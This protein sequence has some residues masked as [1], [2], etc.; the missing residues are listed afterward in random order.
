MIPDIGSL[1]TPCFVVDEAR[2]G[3]NLQLLSRVQAESGAKI[4]IALKG[5]AMFSVFP[6]IRRHLPGAT[7]S[8]LDEAL[9]ARD[10]F[11]GEVHLCAPAYSDADM[12]ELIT[13]ANHI[14]FNS[15]GQWERHRATVAASDRKIEC[16]LRINPGY[17][18]VETEIYNPCAPGS[19]LG[20]PVDQ[21]GGS[22][23]EGI[24]GL[25]FHTLCEQNSDTLER[26]LEVVVKTAGRFF[27]Q[28]RWINFG[29]GHHSTRPDYDVDRLCRV[30]TEFRKCHDLE[31][32]LEPGEAI[33][34]N[35]GFL[36]SS[37]M[38]IVHNGMDIAVLDTSA[39]AHMPDVIEMPYRPVIEG[40][41]EIGQHPHGYRLGGLTCLA[42]DVIGDYSF[43]QPLQVG[44]KLVFHDMAHYTMVKTTTF[45]GVRLPSIYLTNSETGATR[46]VRRFGHE[47]YKSR[48]S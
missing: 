39:T 13:F 10:E 42:G 16:G 24:T 25:H 35:T 8:S 40:A 4:I 27:P 20:I 17:S 48:L 38:D 11:G 12:A 18:E 47:D 41:G 21:L 19:R 46:L 9:L 26:T 6:Q 29:G 1:E 28:I 45:N 37:V 2:L 43:P 23:P 34:L 14:V 5:F 3:K 22:L 31:V 33:A 7:A 36:V 44:Q 30:V 32:Y 15:L